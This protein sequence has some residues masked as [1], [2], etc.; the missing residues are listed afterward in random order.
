MATV[1]PPRIEGRAVKGVYSE[2]LV[3]QGGRRYNPNPVQVVDIPE[4]LY[5]D[6]DTLRLYGTP[7]RCGAYVMRI[8]GDGSR[9]EFEESLWLEFAG[10]VLSRMDRDAAMRSRS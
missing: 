1:N 4:G 7:K 8:S 2:M 6:A 5:W 10:W 3:A 9:V